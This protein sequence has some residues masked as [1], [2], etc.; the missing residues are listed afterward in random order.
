MVLESGGKVMDELDTSLNRLSR[1]VAEIE[2]ACAVREN[3]VKARQQD[4]FS[5]FSAPKVPQ[6]QLV[7]TL[8]SVINNIQFI[9]N[10]KEAA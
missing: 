10:R 3:D 8:D 5:Q 9:L 1:A 7:K 4:L 2:K 6:D